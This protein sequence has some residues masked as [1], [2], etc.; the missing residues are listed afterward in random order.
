MKEK[1]R[2][3][4]AF[5]PAIVVVII[6]VIAYNYG[7]EIGAHF[8]PDQTARDLPTLTQMVMDQ[9]DDGESSGV[10]YVSGIPEEELFNINDYVVS[11]NGYVDQYSVLEKSKKGMR[12]LY[13][14]DISD[15]YY[16]YQKYVNGTDIPSDRPA[17]VKLYN[18]V[19]TVIDTIIKPDMTEYEMELAI[20]DY[21]VRT[22]EYGYVD[23]SK[24]YA[25]RAYGVLVQK[26]AV[27]NGYAEAMKLL[28]DCV[29]IENEIMTGWGGGELHAWNRVCLDGQWY[30]V[31][32]TWN[33]PLP[34]R[35]TYVGHMFFNVTDDIM[36]DDHI[37]EES[38]YEPCTSIEY[39]YFDLNNRVFNNYQDF[40][41]YI[42]NE[43]RK[44]VTATCEVVVKDYS[45]NLYEYDFLGDIPGIMYF[46][47]SVEPYD[48]HHVITI[49][50]NQR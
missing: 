34:D 46:M 4:L 8:H 31:D 20:H 25:Y 24:E 7:W 47:H 36:D 3:Y 41:T 17:A 29:G 45:E 1:S 6:V 13:N 50:L 39:N 33:D 16:V 19:C 32:A 23:Y 11:T 28:M 14:Y 48:E 18:A 44:N 2:A 38:L 30:Q 9:I 49:Y 40:K 15:N 37:W 27:C 10:F 22:C 5:I 26:K 35:G 21:I 12:I 43:A 42:A